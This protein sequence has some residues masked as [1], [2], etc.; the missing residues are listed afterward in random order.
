MRSVIIIVLIL[1]LGLGLGAISM[2]AGDL[3]K[4]VN[5][6]AARLRCPVCTNLSVADS[7]AELSTQMRQLIREKRLQG[8]SEEQIMSYFV[9]R[10]GEWI[11][12]EPKKSGINILLWFAP[13]IGLIVG[14]AII[15]AAVRA[16]GKR[17][18]EAFSEET[19]GTELQKIP[20]HLQD[21]LN[22][23]LKELD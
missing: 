6:I 12:L 2:G 18:G 13:F 20:K 21:R 11:L 16:R 7:N 19:K 1:A 10:Y 5:N 9:S 17:P 22:K 14:G 15:W 8:E 4:E 23:E 3:D